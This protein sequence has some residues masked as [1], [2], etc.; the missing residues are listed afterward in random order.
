MSRGDCPK[1]GTA[2]EHAEHEGLPSRNCSNCKGRWV[3]VLQ[4]E[5]LTEKV[6]VAD[7][8]LRVY[9]ELSGQ[10]LEPAGLTCPSCAEPLLRGSYARIEVDACRSCKGMFLDAHELEGVVDPTTTRPCP[11]CNAPM[12]AEEINGVPANSCRGCGGRWL[13]VP[14][15]EHLGELSAEAR[16]TRDALIRTFASLH[17]AETRKTEI[18]CPTCTS[19]LEACDHEGIEL[20]FC[21]RCRGLFVDAGEMEHVAEKNASA[22]ERAVA[23][24]TSGASRALTG[25]VGSLA[26]LLG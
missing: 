4:L 10:E 5:S 20:D 14:M 9:T 12:R 23:A 3:D 7:E 25:L 26:K 16:L 13:E 8:I 18:A 1:C 15:I 21:C 11:K 6:P 24:A 22:T 2:L 17:D 19:T